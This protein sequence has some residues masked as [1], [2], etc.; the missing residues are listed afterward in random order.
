[1]KAFDMLKRPIRE[2]IYESGWDSLRHIQEAA[3]KFTHQKNDN[4]ILA[5]PTASGKTEAAFLPAINSIESWHEGVKI[6]YIS[7]LI[8]LI[9]DQFNRIE[10]L[11]NSLNISVTSW[12]GEA[13]VSE[14]KKL[15]KQPNG[16]VLITPE[17]LEAMLVG[18]PQEANYL[19]NQVEWV[20]IDEI[21]SFMDNNR[22]IQLRSVL[23]RLYQYMD[24]PPRAV[25]LSATLNREDY[26]IA[27]DFFDNGRETSILL[28]PS[29]NA[30]DE[31][32]YYLQGSKKQTSFREAIDLIY[33]ASK[34]EAMLV[35]PN[36]RNLVEEIGASL[37]ELA[38][39]ESSNRVSYFVHHASLTKKTRLMAEK[40]AKE[41]RGKL[42]T[43]CCTSTLELGIDIGA[44]DSV[45]QYQA[46]YSVASLAQRLGRS[47][48]RTGK[49]FL[50]FMATNEWSLLQGLAAIE[51]FNEGSIDQLDPITKPY[52]V[53]AHQLLAILIER[54]GMMLE[55][56]L[57]F[58][59]QRQVWQGI[60]DEEIQS[61]LVHLIDH[62]Y[63]EPL[64]NGEFISG[65]ATEPLLR[66]AEFYTQFHTPPMMAVYHEL[67]KIGEIS[68]IPGLQAEMEI[69]LI[70]RVWEILEIDYDKK[71][72]NV[73]PAKK[74]RAFFEGYGQRNVSTLLRQ[75]M[76]TILETE[77][78]LE[79][80]EPPIVKALED[81]G[82][83]LEQV[84]G[85]YFL[86]NDQGG[87]DL[88][89]FL[90]SKVN[91]TLRIL[92]E[93]R[94][95]DRYRV[96]EH[97]S[98]IVGPNLPDLV[99]Q[100]SGTDLTMDDL[101]DYLFQQDA[102]IEQFTRHLKY[103]KLLPKELLVNYI[104]HNQLDLKATIAY[105]S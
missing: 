30:H 50:H 45:V 21:H 67:K 83:K 84:H 20:I 35:F 19:F 22:G 43:I 91:R 104:L 69:L 62:D 85:Y 25:G 105:L 17:S 5:A 96:D 33:Q 14:K 2:Y 61:L 10:G 6:L 36:T 42:F 100:A 92:F 39:Q 15:F 71:Q 16:I 31:R 81:L 63:I 76:C 27:K 88:L 53:L 29:R 93:K 3:I 70:G 54:N 97:R 75:R 28:D 90:S 101:Y 103:Q 1:M 7:P 8:A 40:F 98:A 77:S 60:T 48:R 23:G 58:I 102:M 78:F 66:M 11:C 87:P 79:S 59:K 74:G 37:S 57:G 46:P 18:R 34:K 72:L 41:S 73:K 52:D 51:L 68:V 47:G 95:G 55:D 64:D 9:N 24:I 82:S 32:I 89:T 44:V 12:H 26:F 13:S 4:F 56:L 65:T 99:R 80:Y 94:S 49:S 38:S 86:K